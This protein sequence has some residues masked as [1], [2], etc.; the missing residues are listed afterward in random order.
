[1]LSGANSSI[2][3]T[4]SPVSHFGGIIVFGL[5]VETWAQDVSV[6]QLESKVAREEKPDCQV[7]HLPLQFG[8]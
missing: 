7:S 3:V 2:Y 6:R 5:A 1:M 8:W 4:V